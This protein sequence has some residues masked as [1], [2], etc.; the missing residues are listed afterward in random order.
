MSGALIE[1][2]NA[3]VSG[4]IDYSQVSKHTFKPELVV[5]DGN[6]R[7]VLT[8][9]QKHLK[10]CDEFWFSVAF[11]TTSGIACLK[12]QLIELDAEGIR[13]RILVSQYLNFTQPQ[14]LREL[15]KFKN[16]EV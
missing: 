2:Q 9:I 4:F 15:L 7:K 1:L 10:S 6:G 12:Q 11:V 16:M 13:G 5:N 3:L 8:S 14:A